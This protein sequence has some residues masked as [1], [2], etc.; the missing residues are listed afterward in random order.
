MFAPFSPLRSLELSVSSKCFPELRAPVMLSINI[1]R[2]SLSHLGLFQ[3]FSDTDRGCL[4]P[5]SDWQMLLQVHPTSPG[6][7]DV[8]S[9][10]SSVELFGGDGHNYRTFKPL[11]RLWGSGTDQNNFQLIGASDF[12]YKINGNIKHGAQL[13]EL[14]IFDKMIK[15]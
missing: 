9:P 12:F 11:K 1:P 14:I 4:F 6:A 8:W 2:L 15:E 10:R 5:V 3:D 7:L 13:I